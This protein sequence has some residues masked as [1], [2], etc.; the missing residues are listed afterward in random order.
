MTDTTTPSQQRVDAREVLRKLQWN[1]RC[2]ARG[3]CPWC[4]NLRLMGHSATCDLAAALAQADDTGSG[5]P[6]RYWHVKTNGVYEIIGKGNM[7]TAEPTR[8]L[9]QVVVYRA[10]G[11]SQ[12]WIRP[13]DEFNDGR[14]EKLS[15]ISTGG[16]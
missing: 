10:P 8:D 15:P 6:E 9:T 16:E 7:Q 12:L 14:F 1:D 4:G 11:C 13:L 3:Y 5:E 2:T